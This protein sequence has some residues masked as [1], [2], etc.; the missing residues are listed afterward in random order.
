MARCEPPSSNASPP[1]DPSDSSL[2]RR[3]QGGSQ[4]AATQ[5]YLRYAE[6]L[7]GLVRSESS[8]ALARREDADDILQSI[9]TSFFRGVGQG[10]YEV[11][12]GDELWKLLLVIA[13]NKICA[14]G[15]YHRAAKRDVRRT[16]GGEFLDRYS[17]QAR[18]AD[19]PGFVFL[20]L[21]IEEALEHWQPLQQQMIGLRIE[22]HEIADIATRTQ[23]SKRS[24]ERVLQE[25]RQQLEK[26]LE[27]D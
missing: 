2:L 4:E 19:D 21:V 9:F 22:G 27:K 13:L 1:L 14:K 20:K 25:F 8:A 23:R 3:V 16:V 17:R 12:A 6:R 26:I 10:F 7:R 5:L 24:V 18:D 15:I 11:P